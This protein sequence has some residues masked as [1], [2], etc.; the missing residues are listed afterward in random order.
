MA[1]STPS[2]CSISGR[3]SAE[4]YSNI[5]DKAESEKDRAR[6]PRELIR[7]KS[8]FFLQLYR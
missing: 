6:R 8:P 1:D 2:T 7:G 3:R 5:N 4:K